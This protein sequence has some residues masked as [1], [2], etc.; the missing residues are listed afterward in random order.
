M[1]EFSAL[2]PAVSRTAWTPENIAE[3]IKWGILGD[4]SSENIVHIRPRE[5]SGHILAARVGNRASEVSKKV[6]G[7]RIMQR[8]VSGEVKVLLV[9]TSAT[10]SK[11]HWYLDTGESICGQ[12]IVWRR[13]N[14]V[15]KW[16]PLPNTLR[17]STMC[18]KVDHEVSFLSPAL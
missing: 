11:R 5:S 14:K 8:K 1:H 6:K 18:R 16:V 17:E 7:W 4:T 3:T 2:T 13:A 12:I 10:R 9:S 15:M